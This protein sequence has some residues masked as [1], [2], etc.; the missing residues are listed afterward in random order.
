M[1]KQSFLKGTLILIVAGM[2]TRFLGFINR[3]VVARVM[4]QEGVGLYMMAL[5]TFVLVINLTQ[6][7]LPVAI[8]KR[9]AEAEAMGDKKKI[10]AILVISLSITTLLSVIF[11]TAMILLAPLVAKHLLTDERVLYP[12]LAISPIVPI[13][14]ISSVLRGYFQGRQNMLP[15]AISQVIEQIVRITLVAFFV[16][17]LLPYGVEYAAAG[18]MIS[19]IIGEF[20]SLMYMI[21]MFKQKKRVKIFNRFLSSIKSGKQTFYELMRIA[22]PTTGSRLV[23]SVSY[24]LEP[25]LVVQSLAIAGIAA[26]EATKQYGTL[27]GYAMPLLFL[28]T[29][30][31]NSLS[32]ALVP[33]ISEAN[34]KNQTRLIH[35]R[36]QQSI[37]LSLAS[38]GIATVILFIFASPLLTYM[39]NDDSATSFLYIMAPFFLLLYF[40]TPLQSGLQALDY[41]KPAMWNSV[42]GS[43]VKFVALVVLAS[44]PELGIMGVALAI[45][46]GVVVVTLLHYASLKKAIQ[47]SMP[48]KEWAKIGALLGLTYAAAQ[49][50]KSMLDTVGGNVF[51]FLGAL[52][53]LGI[54]YLLLL[55]IL[56][57]VKKDEWKQIP[58]INRFL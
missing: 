2:I 25:I 6:F 37:R 57:I 20:V 55:Q 42:I 50:M 36:L 28:P 48:F 32:I 54:I 43:I 40:Q 34:A 51:L 16:K 47:F 44:R 23:G 30:I 12:L 3:I 9:V 24:F 46:I 52:L 53:L 29:F 14:A 22:I 49:F 7:G 21:W 8:S 5:P 41:A 15:Q 35:Y 1:T 27:T 56:G 13:V 17:A 45:V 38:G 10:K 18:A 39:Y 26:V 33:A 31:T 4:G 19:A 11:T 58:I